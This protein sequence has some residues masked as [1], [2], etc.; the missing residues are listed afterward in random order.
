MNYNDQPISAA[1]AAALLRHLVPSVARVELHPQWSDG[2]GETVR[3]TR[4]VPYNAEG[5]IIELLTVERRYVAGLLR[6]LDGAA[7]DLD[8][9][10]TFDVAAGTLTATFPVVL[11]LPEALLSPAADAYRAA[12]LVAQ[13]H[14]LED[15]AEPPLAVA[16]PDA[17]RDFA[18][19]VADGFV[20]LADWPPRGGHD[21]GC[22][23]VGGVGPCSCASVC[24]PQPAPARPVADVPVVGEAL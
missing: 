5:D 20:T 7:V 16:V 21:V 4:A 17:A 15:D 23:Y 1:R 14:E 24:D 2:S 18:R 13:R 10:Q 9:P 12:Q 8:R 3:R 11:S 19:S 22:A 6:R